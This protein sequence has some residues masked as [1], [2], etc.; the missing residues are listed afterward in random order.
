MV[1]KKKNLQLLTASIQPTV[2]FLLNKPGNLNE[3]F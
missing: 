2:A 1:E 3:N